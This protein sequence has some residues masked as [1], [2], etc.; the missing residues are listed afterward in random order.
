MNPPAPVGGKTAIWDV[1]DKNNIV[2]IASF[3]V[4]GL[5]FSGNGWTTAEQDALFIGD[6]IDELVRAGWAF[7]FVFTQV[8]SETTNKPRTG[9]YIIDIQ[10]LD[11]PIFVQ[12]FENETVGL[13][14]NF[15]VR[16]DKLYLA[17][18]TA[19]TRVMKIDRDTNGQ[20]L[21]EQ[22]ASM[23][24]EPRLPGKI[25]NIEQ[26]QNFG[27]S[28]L[29]QWGVYALFPSDTIVASDMNNGLIVLRLSDEPCARGQCN[30]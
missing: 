28:F 10:D 12:R 1:T 3:R 8:P 11:N 6:E 21:L 22:I 26:E 23:D 9:T 17:S 5:V 29:G 27:S 18:Y 14:K 4:P 15:M 20:V 13:D 16:G 2:E 25:L 30:R 7:S 24:T 19:G